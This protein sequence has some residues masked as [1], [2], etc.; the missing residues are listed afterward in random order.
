MHR[1]GPVSVKGHGNNQGVARKYG[2]HYFESDTES[3]GFKMVRFQ[4]IGA[5]IIIIFL[6]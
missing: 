1:L 4:I 3:S 6:N 2:K 5:L